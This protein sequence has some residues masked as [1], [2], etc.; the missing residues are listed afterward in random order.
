MIVDYA[1]AQGEIG[2]RQFDVCV[3]GG[4]PAGITLARKLAASGRTV[5][6]M[7]GGGLEFD[8]RSQDLYTGDCIGRDYYPLDTTRLRYLGGASNHWGGLC[9][10]LEAWDFRP[11][12]FLP[13]SGWPISRADLD[14]YSTEADDIVSIPNAEAYPDKQDKLAGEDFRI[15]RF[16]HSPPI[17]FG[18]KYVEELRASPQITLV[19]NANLVDIDLDDSHRTVT[20]ARFK[21]YDPGD[22]GIEIRA[23]VFCLCMGG[24]ENPRFLLNATRQVP[25]GIGN[26]HDLVGRGFCEHLGYSVGKVLF[27][28]KVPTAREYEPTPEFLAREQISNFN[29]LLGTKARS[30]TKELARTAICS[31]EFVERL[32]RAVLNVGVNCDAGGMDSFFATR[33]QEQGV[34]WFG[35]ITEQAVNPLS[36]VT[37]SDTRDMFGHRRI[38]L[39][40]QYCDI[41]LRTMRTA[42]M[43]MAE[44]YAD[45]GVG[46]IQFKDW[47]LADDMQPPQ[48]GTGNGEVGLHHHMCTTRMNADPALGV[49]DANCRVHSVSNLY[50]GG[51]SVF[52]SG[53]YAN[54]TYTIVQLALRLGEHLSAS[55]RV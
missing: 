28:G 2:A 1:A 17:R 20:G 52:A 3:V 46:R 21:S 40:W 16:R 15:I 22:P 13:G 38:A 26:E 39:D 45:N 48:L 19:L 42:C 25:H 41:D 35:L 32:A 6:L 27:E 4:G 14:P 55:L 23:R 5:A 50:I 8:Q 34:G 9:R 31:T 18:E 53:G 30:L 10:P 51:C 43:R 37:L 49:V 24:L 7:E 29:M 11:K 36:R 12:T 44:R 54:P 47:I 33:R